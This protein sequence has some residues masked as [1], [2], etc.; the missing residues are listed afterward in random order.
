[1]NKN[2]IYEVYNEIPNKQLNTIKP[3][4][5]TPL[6]RFPVFLSKISQK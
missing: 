1:M 5:E 2:I 4:V 6:S 3:I